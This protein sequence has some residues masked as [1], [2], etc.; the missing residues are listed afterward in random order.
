MKDAEEKLGILSIKLNLMGNR[1]W[2]DRMFLVPGGKPVFGEFKRV[3]K[4]A[5]PLQVHRRDQMEL[6]GYSAY[7]WD[8]VEECLSTLKCHLRSK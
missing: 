4:P 8:S 3:G 6:I 7:I 2:M 1:G 5:R